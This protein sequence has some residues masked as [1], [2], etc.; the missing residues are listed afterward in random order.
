MLKMSQK[1][2]LIECIFSFWTL[3]RLSLVGGNRP[4]FCDLV[5]TR[6]MPQLIVLAPTG[7]G[8]IRESRYA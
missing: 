8:G 1:N 3:R 7:T 2:R 4:L 5:L 6:P